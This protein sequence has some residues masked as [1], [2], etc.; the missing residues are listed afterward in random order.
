[1]TTVTP[2]EFLGR[3]FSAPN[4]IWPD[5][6]PGHGIVSTL[7]P[8]LT[9]LSK[10]GECPVVLPRRDLAALP[11]EIY[12]ICWDT[13]HSGRIRALLE[14]AVAHH[15]CHFDGRVAI[16]DPD[17]A[18]HKAV[19]DFIGPGTTFVL[20]PPSETAG[21][22][23]R[24]LTRLV[25]TLAEAPLRTPPLA[26]PLG[27]MLREF[28]LAL[29][30]GS[31][32]TSA[33]LLREIE[34]FGGISHENIAFLQIRRLSRLGQ[35]RE[36]LADGSLPTLVYTEPP[37][38]VRE[39]V[40]SAWGR[41]RILPALAADGVDA[42]LIRIGE[43]GPDI[44]LLVDE[45]VAATLDGEVATVG[46][47]VT[48]ARADRALAASFAEHPG[49][50]DAVLERLSPLL[51]TAEPEPELQPV[52]K[53][54]LAAELQAQ[55]E[56]EAEPVPGGPSGAGSWQEW[57]AR[58]GAPDLPPLEAGGA[59]EWPPA[60]TVD[61]DLATAV[62]ALDDL[63]VDDLLSGVACF[64]ETDDP[65]HPATA[66]SAA[67]I[68]RH[69]LAERFDPAD[70]GALCSLLQV[71]LRG[72]PGAREYREA[73]DGIRSYATQ[74][75]AVG[76]AVRAVDLADAVAC[77]PAVDNDARTGLIT[78]LLSPLNQQRTR[79]S[80]PLRALADLVC[81]DVGLA[82]DWIIP[83]SH[84]VAPPVPATAVDPFIL[85][86]SLDPGTLSRV[87][88][89]IEV[90]WPQAR[91]EV[92][93]V[94]VGGDPALRQYARDADIIVLATRRAAHA[95]TG[96]IADNAGAQ[97]GFYYPDGS[98]TGSMLRAV[99]AAIGEWIG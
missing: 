19:L 56:P 44:A 83:E 53:P 67:L 32:E 50:P 84:E 96:Y 86:Y 68:N 80:A 75:V 85:L 48:L 94:K 72:A 26:R 82:F 42:A 29:A 88:A 43:P 12:V 65:E 87:K 6:D 73:L 27:R 64:L 31:A 34:G 69:L 54:V 37:R 3:F 33:T 81:S 59:D 1:M 22:T 47:L 46:A 66:T 90:Q 98:G 8:F 2:D 41:D 18:V 23:F 16:L 11:A 62:D 35:D 4:T 76:T 89:T 55:P 79:L 21:Q 45:R 7:R 25:R 40:L 58:L 28:D 13:A 15:W 5:A 93:S 38:V 74:W 36:L 52:L 39:A 63:A 92:S 24:A 70:L 95:A 91:V 77:G 99:E 9:A 71:F 30:S 60:W 49:L 20:R 14:A 97:A 61:A 78:T 51:A 17:D 57:V 10:R